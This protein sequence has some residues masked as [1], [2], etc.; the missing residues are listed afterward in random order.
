M[1]LVPLAS[2]AGNLVGGFMPGLVAA[3][4]GL[5]L[6]GPV[7][8]RYPLLITA[9]VYGLV[10]LPALIT[11]REVRAGSAHETAART[12][13]APYALIAIVALTRLL[14]ISAAVGI[15]VFFNVYLDAALRTPTSLIGT[16]AAVG[17][18]IAVP[19][20]LAAP[21][22]MERLG[23]P[24][25]IVWGALSQGLT[26]L[27]LALVPHWGA[28]GLGFAA[29]T[30]AGSIAGAAAMTFTQELV[31]PDWRPLMSGAN[32]MTW[33]LSSAIVAFAGGYVIAGL[34]YRSFFLMA[35]AITAVGALLFWAYFRVPR[36]EFART[37]E[38]GEEGLPDGIA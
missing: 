18:T 4:V 29:V 25:T 13:R 14:Y 10:A 23:E 34:G 30:V 36:G 16:L 17:N 11:T 8:Y 27:P 26:T 19:A 31:S 28:A 20:A 3:S 15:Q 24:R 12:G 38:V 32:S 33:G 22:V 7:P 5:S 9:V 35:A 2:F 37:L 6:D 21:L 1:A